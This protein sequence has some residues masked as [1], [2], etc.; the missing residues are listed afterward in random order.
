MFINLNLLSKDEIENHFEKLTKDNNDY[1]SENEDLNPLKLRMKGLGEKLT[2]LQ[3]FIVVYNISKRRGYEN[4]FSIEK[5]ERLNTT[6]KLIEKYKYPIRVILEEKN[7][8]YRNKGN[9]KEQ[10]L[11]L[12]KDYKNELD[13]ILLTQVENNLILHETKEKIM[14]IVFRQRYFEE[15]TNSRRFEKEEFKNKLRS[16]GQNYYPTWHDAI[17]NCT[18]YK[19]EKR[20][21]RNSIFSDLYVIYNELS[22]IT[23]NVNKKERS[24]I[25]KYVTNEYLRKIEFSKKIVEEAFKEF[26]IPF[27]NKSEGVS[28]EKKNF[29]LVK[30]NKFNSNWVKDEFKKINYDY[31]KI[32]DT[33][34]EKFGSILGDNVTPKKV[35]KELNDIGIDSSSE[36]FFKKISI[37][38]SGRINVSKEFIKDLIEE[39]FEIGTKMGEFAFSILEKNKNYS[40]EKRMN[41]I[42]NDTKKLSVEEAL[43]YSFKPNIND[44]DMERNAVVFRSINQLR[45]VIRALLKKYENFE[46]I[47]YEVA[48]DL[49]AAISERKSIQGF[50]QKNEKENNRIKAILGEM[51]IRITL[52]NIEKVKLW[53]QQKKSSSDDFAYDFYDFSLDKKIYL[54]DIFGGGYEVDHIIPYAIKNDNTIWNKVL[55]SR[56]NNQKKGKR[57]PIEY[58]VSK[59]RDT[60]EIEKWKKD[61]KT[62]GIFKTSNLKSESISRKLN[63]LFMLNSSRDIELNFETKDLND[64]RYIS[65]YFGLYFKREF[66]IYS[67]LTEGS[68]PNINSVKGSVTSLYR[69]EWLKVNSNGEFNPWGLDKKVRDITPYHHS[70]DAIVLSQFEN[71]TQIE[72]LTSFVSIKNYWVFLK[73]QIKE[74]SISI[75]EAKINLK[76]TLEN[77]LKNFNPNRKYIKEKRI[78]YL[79]SFEEKLSLNFNGKSNINTSSFM[80]PLVETLSDDIL[81]LIPVV[82]EFERVVKEIEYE[83]KDKKKFIFEKREYEFRNLR[84]VS[85]EEWSNKN[86]RD[87]KL[88]PWPSYKIE[89]RIR[90]S[91][92]G[93]ELPVNKNDKI[94]DKGKLVKGAYQ[95]GK[96]QENKYYEDKNGTIWDKASYFGIDLTKG[97][98]VGFISMFDIQRNKNKY[99]KTIVPGTI[100]KFDDGYFRYTGKQN[101]SMVNPSIFRVYNGTKKYNE[102]FKNWPLLSINKIKNNDNFKIVELSILGKSQ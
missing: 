32:D 58:F 52:S 7:G 44:R 47:N 21:T 69:R 4:L 64:I 60:K 6:K 23:E 45:L 17:G 71:Q 25:F 56:D 2:N 29:F 63:S 85:P 93:S 70:V 10:I 75:D 20:L 82:L 14:D 54:N 26:D 61:I 12:R 53:E 80:K 18:Y 59:G 89:K 97:N 34:L 101:D 50:Q 84:E 102:V 79:R 86:N 100:F 9:K 33:Q 41:E 24:N 3:L 46:V 98:E 43:K 83:D 1:S 76:E 55:T 95:D 77:L 91:V 96:L 65:K 78:E 94:N 90:G 19:E 31:L 38:S 15:G 39:T 36:D 37:F 22:K 48:R 62:F 11:F 27:V 13:R 5:E 66:E 40:I 8:S 42:S 87:I 99:K 81:S 74:G 49:Y 28:F 68:M 35:I 88:F 51:G 92:F 67:K 72:F 30:V 73:K 57:T 16:Q